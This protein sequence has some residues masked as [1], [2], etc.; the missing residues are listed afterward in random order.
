MWRLPKMFG[1]YEK[2]VHSKEVKVYIFDDESYAAMWLNIKYDL[3]EDDTLK[4]LDKSG[5]IYI[6]ETDDE[7]YRLTNFGYEADFVYT[8]II[9]TD[10]LEEITMEQEKDI[11]FEIM[12]KNDE[13]CDQFE[14]WIRNEYKRQIKTK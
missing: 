11:I 14:F 4:I 12:E 2:N 5:N 1:L 3:D 9:V 7:V 10:C 6:Q 8:S 13:M